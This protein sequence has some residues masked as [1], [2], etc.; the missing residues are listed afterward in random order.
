MD[1]DIIKSIRGRFG[2]FQRA[3]YVPVDILRMTDG[4][5][6]ALLDLRLITHEEYKRAYHDLMRWV[7]PQ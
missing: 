3:G 7:Y 2:A 6:L 5:L 4:Y 1:G